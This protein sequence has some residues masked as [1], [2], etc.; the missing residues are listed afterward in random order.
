[1]ETFKKKIDKIPKGKIQCYESADIMLKS[2]SKKFTM[3]KGINSTIPKNNIKHLYGIKDSITTIEIN[4]VNR[5]I[6]NKDLVLKKYNI[7]NR[8]WV[9]RLF[10]H[11]FNIF[12]KDDKIVIAQSWFRVMNYKIIYEFDKVQ[13]CKFLDKLRTMLKMYNKAPQKLFKLFKYDVKKDAD[14][15][16]LIKYITTVDNFEIQY[17]VKYKLL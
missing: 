12:I 4:I 8:F 1:M 9:P 7:K 3:Y 6:E 2:Y 5:K 13:F 11:S 14:I 15:K 16:N 10:N 17:E